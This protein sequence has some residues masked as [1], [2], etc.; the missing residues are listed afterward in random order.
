MDWTLLILA[1]LAA[2]VAGTMFVRDFERW[3]F[4]PYLISHPWRWL[5]LTVLLCVVIG[6]VA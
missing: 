6:Y 1:A 3:L 4:W 2:A 5:A